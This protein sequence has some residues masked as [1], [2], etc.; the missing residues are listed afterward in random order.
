MTAG[1]RQSVRD[2]EAGNA[3][4]DN[5]SG[6]GSGYYGGSGSGGEKVIREIRVV[7][8]GDPFETAA[9][10]AAKAARVMDLVDQLDMRAREGG[11]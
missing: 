5:G 1:E 6:S 9:E 8:V 2:A 11:A 10:R 7:Y 4:S 3:L